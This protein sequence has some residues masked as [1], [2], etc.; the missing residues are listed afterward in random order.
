MDAI[1][2]LLRRK[3]PREVQRVV[4]FVDPAILHEARQL[5]KEEGHTLSF[6]FEYF[7]KGYI[8]RNPSILA[9]IDQI[10]RDQGSPARGPV[11][12][13]FSRREADEIFDLIERGEE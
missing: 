1:Q 10:R 3:K 2:R 6:I 13:T 5:M 7:L 8:A 11:N 4:V 12:H 9:L